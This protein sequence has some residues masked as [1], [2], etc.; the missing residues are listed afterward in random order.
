MNRVDKAKELYDASLTQLLKQKGLGSPPQQ[1]YLRAFKTERQLE[2]WAA[3]DKEFILLKTYPFTAYSGALGPKQREG[4]GQIPE[5]FYGIDLFNPK[6]NFLLSMRVNYPNKADQVRN[7]NE[8]QMGGDIY[9]HGSSVSI[10]C[11]P[12]GDEPIREL[13]WL[14]W[15]HHQSFPENIPVHIFP[16]RMTK[17]NLKKHNSKHAAFWQQLEPMYR[18][19]E[20]HHL[21]GDV[22][23]DAKGNYTLSLPGD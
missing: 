8:K 21:L 3:H 4:D 17:E 23:V 2:V 12:I 11:I 1:L 14:C 16:F 19:F 15:K 13:Y 6:S 20:S 22:S 9:I 18:F 10:G 7:K 5:G